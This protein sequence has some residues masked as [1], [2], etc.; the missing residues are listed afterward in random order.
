MFSL[1]NHLSI[2][3]LLC[4]FSGTLAFK[5]TNGTPLGG[6]GTGY[7][8]FNAKKGEF[9]V[10]GKA[11]PAA[12]DGYE[13]SSRKPSSGGFHF[14]ANGE[15]TRNAKTDNEEAECPL[16]RA[17]FGKTG[18]V[19][20]KLNAFGPFVPGENPE[21]YKMA[22]SPMALF[23]VTAINTNAEEVAVA[24]AMEFANG[25]LLGGANSGSAMEGNKSISF[26]GNE[27][28]TLAADCDNT[29][30]EFSVGNVGSGFNGT[31]SNGDGNAV[32]AKCMVA[33][34]D[35][36]RFKFVL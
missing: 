12:A 22:T 34:G 3:V 32:A 25:G 28:A 7:V 11:P 14:F 13:F 15:T 10:S 24:A 23:E 19:T 6:M 29:S 9:A 20:F 8:K 36:V 31:L 5:G 27:N 17:D 33:A 35:T 16:Y 2:I 18:G 1:R 26:S 4:M 30:A 21:H